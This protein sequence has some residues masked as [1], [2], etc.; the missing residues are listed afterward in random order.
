[1][2]ISETAIGHGGLHGSGIEFIVTISKRAR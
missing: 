1:M 2:V